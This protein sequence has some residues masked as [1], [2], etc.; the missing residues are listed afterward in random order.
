MRPTL[1]GF[2]A[3]VSTA[4]VIGVVLMSRVVSEGLTAVWS[5]YRRVSSSTKITYGLAY[6]SLL[7]AIVIEPERINP[8]HVA[9]FFT[10]LASIMGMQD[11]D[12]A[13]R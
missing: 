5:K 4:I 13:I 9:V 2:I 7:A 1:L 11:L 3:G 12:Q 10:I 8:V 6:V